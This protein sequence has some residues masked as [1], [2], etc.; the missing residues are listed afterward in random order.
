MD[1]FNFLSYFGGQ[2]LPNTPYTINES[3]LLAGL[4]VSGPAYEVESIDVFKY[5][6]LDI[7]GALVGVA[8][9]RTLDFN[10]G[11]VNYG[12]YTLFKYTVINPTTGVRITSVRKDER[13]VDNSG[14]PA[15][16]ND[17]A[18]TRVGQ[19][20]FNN[21]VN[22]GS[23]LARNTQYTFNESDLLAPFNAKAG[24]TLVVS[25]Y[26]D[27]SQLG[28]PFASGAANIEDIGGTAPNRLF[29]LTTGASNIEI[30]FRYTVSNFQSYSS[31]NY[32]TATNGID[33]VTVS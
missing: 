11:N 17:T 21:V 27:G 31:N 15:N 26:G 2:I 13:S 8:P 20:R 18:I 22:G 33:I 4:G 5:G 6:Q 25:A 30:D 32:Y 7:P 28:V 9:N 24:D 19:F 1:T 10:I 3:D 14:L 29:R 16:P 12:E 23:A